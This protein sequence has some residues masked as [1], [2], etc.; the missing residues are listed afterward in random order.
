MQVASEIKVNW[1][2]NWWKCKGIV[3]LQFL[4]NSVWFLGHGSDIEMNENIP[5]NPW[6][7]G[8]IEM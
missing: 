1:N 4:T 5:G 7:I 8:P 2:N 3:Y 6:I